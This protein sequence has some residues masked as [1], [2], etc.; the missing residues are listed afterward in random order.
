MPD[1]PL[2]RVSYRWLEV[3]QEELQAWVEA[4]LKDAF[5]PAVMAE[6]MAGIGIDMSRLEAMIGKQPGFDPYRVLCLD[7]SASDDEVKRRY[8]ELIHKLHPDKSG[9]P[10]TSFLLQMVM[11][12]YEII[13]KERGWQ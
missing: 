6:I 7:R 3:L 10:G 9:T 13:K 5:N 4:V 2:I 11:A 12:A 1:N 8:H